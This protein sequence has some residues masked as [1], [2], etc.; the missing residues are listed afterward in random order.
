MVAVL[1]SLG[2]TELVTSI[3]ALSPVGA[4]AILA[5]TGDLSRFTHARAVVKHAGLAPTARA[6]GEYT[7][8]TRITGHGRPGLRLALWRAVFG[9]LLTNPEMKA[10]YQHLTTRAH[11]PLTDGQARAA[12]AAALLRQIYLIAT[13]GT[14]YQPR[15]ALPAAA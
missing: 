5:E 10:R 11:K 14:P 12:L 2:L 6:S 4:A 8:V 7:G 13:T 9:A 3:P 1:D 15:N